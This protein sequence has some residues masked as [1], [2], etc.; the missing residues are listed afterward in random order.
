MSMRGQEQVEKRY[1]PRD[2]TLKFVKRKDDLDPVCDEDDGLRAEMSCGHAVTPDS[3]TQ[4]CRSQLDDVCPE[5]TGKQ[6]LGKRQWVKK[7]V[8]SMLLCY[9]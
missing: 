3:L 7:T 9:K 2:T 4:W 8:G 6:T 5:N 1:D